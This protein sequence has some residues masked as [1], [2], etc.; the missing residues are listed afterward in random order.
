MT[1]KILIK[2]SDLVLGYE[3]KVIISGLNFT[4]NSG[5]YLCITGKNGS[6]K[7]TLMKVL[8]GLMK[9]MAGQ[10]S[11]GAGI[12]A[13]EIGYLP[14]QTQIQ[15]DFP[16]T[17]RE[18]AYSGLINRT[19]LRPFYTPAEKKIAESNMLKLGIADIAGRCYRE[20]SGGQQ[21]RTLLARALNATRKVLL[22]DEP[23]AGLDPAAA[24]ELYKIIKNLNDEGTTIIMI[25]HDIESSLNY[26]NHTLSID[27]YEG[28]IRINE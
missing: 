16:A 18:V 12:K 19:G 26:A 14:Q 3:G 2:C 20:L 22:L 24:L 7:S 17:V 13:T 8:L 21:Q 25:S 4:V 5:D 10:I 11:W 9:P 1:T 28:G 23:V 15:K 6:G 27:N